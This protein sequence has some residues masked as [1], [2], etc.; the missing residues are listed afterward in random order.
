MNEPLNGNR[1]KV[2]DPEAV[3][4]NKPIGNSDSNSSSSSDSE[5]D[6]KQGPGIP[7]GGRVTQ[8][9]G[10]ELNHAKCID[11]HAFYKLDWSHKDLQHFHRPDV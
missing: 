1:S 8:T 5:E 3:D 4:T 10:E 9:M 7:T 6:A 2:D 11:G